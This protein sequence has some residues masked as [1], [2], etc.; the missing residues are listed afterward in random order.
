[1]AI[2]SGIPRPAMKSS[3]MAN[4]KVAF[5]LSSSEKLYHDVGWENRLARNDNGQFGEI[6]PR[7][8]RIAGIGSLYLKTATLH[9]GFA[10]ANDLNLRTIMTFYTR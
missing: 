4:R 5:A 6:I 2:K 3:S 9:N 8:N 10:E 1:M 7:C